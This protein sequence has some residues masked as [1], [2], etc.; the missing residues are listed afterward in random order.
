MDT[1]HEKPH[2]EDELS[3][4]SRPQKYDRSQVEIID[5]GRQYFQQEWEYSKPVDLCKVTDEISIATG[6]SIRTLG[7][8][9]TINDINNWLFAAGKYVYMTRSDIAPYEISSPVRKIVTD[10][11]LEKKHLPKIDNIYEIIVHVQ[12][13]DVVHLNLFPGF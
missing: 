7:Q 11:L 2:D 12:V 10:T 3:E 6:A 5:H 13:K 4:F 9:K 8:L 1:E